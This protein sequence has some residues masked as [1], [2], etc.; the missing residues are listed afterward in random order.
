M[1]VDLVLH[2][3]LVTLGQ[4]HN[5]LA[6][7]TLVCQAQLVDHVKALVAPAQDQRVVGLQHV[8]LPLLQLLYLVSD[9]VCAAQKMSVALILP[10][11]CP[12]RAHIK[13]AL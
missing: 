10:N 9:R 4:N 2:V 13:N 12:G 6:P 11:S 8:A 5:G 1:A 7:R 3:L